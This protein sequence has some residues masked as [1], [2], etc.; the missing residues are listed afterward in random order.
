[1]AEL[2]VNVVIDTDQLLWWAA[3]HRELE[4]PSVATALSVAAEH[5]A[6]IDPPDTEN[7]PA[8]GYPAGLDCDELRRWADWHADR[9][10]AGVAHI[11]Y[12]AA[13]A[14][15]EES[16]IAGSEPAEGRGSW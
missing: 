2:R 5:Y 12:E 10:P 11:L 7:P 9:A 13:A 15:V 1:M 4:H 3:K 6:A 14:G 8:P 16:S